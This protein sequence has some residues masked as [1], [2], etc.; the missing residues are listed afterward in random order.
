VDFVEARV[1]WHTLRA[2][3]LGSIRANPARA[4][5]LSRKLG[6]P[7][8]KILYHL[9]VLERSKYIR[10][11]EGEDPDAVDPVFEAVFR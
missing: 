11:A 5:E 10:R 4:T 9:S 7:L 1:F 2:K 8:P 3:I 6:P